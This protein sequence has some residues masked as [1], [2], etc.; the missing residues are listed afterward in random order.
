M[1]HL[2]ES[3]LKQEN[4]A[5]RRN[6]IGHESEAGDRDI[7]PGE[8]VSF[9]DG[10]SRQHENWLVT[11][12]ESRDKERL[13]GI[14]NRRLKGVSMDRADGNQRAYIEVGE[15]PDEH[16]VHIVENPTRIRF[17][18]TPSGEHQ[19]LEIASA[20]GTTT[21]VRFRSAM[22]PEMLDGIVA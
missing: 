14:T 17:K 2:E 21:I 22:R 13:V 20:D 3:K 11:V 19:G 8:W 1:K 9:L 12:E 15:K 5:G 6:Q 18:Q 4:D 16:S 10:F 7:P